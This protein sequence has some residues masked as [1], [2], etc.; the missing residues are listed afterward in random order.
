MK[1][2][3]FELTMDIPRAYKCLNHKVVRDMK[4]WRVIVAVTLLGLAANALAQNPI[5]SISGIVQEQMDNAG[6]QL[7]EQAAKH[8]EEGNLTQ[9][10]IAKDID[11][12]KKNLTMQA[13]SQLGKN[14][15]ATLDKLSEKAAE[16]LKSQMNEKVPVPQQPGFPVV[17]AVLGIL[18]TVCLIRK[19]V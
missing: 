17:L 5:E 2:K 7:R 13:K 16:D 18:G 15:S 8:I 11:A 1:R 12:T 9:E 6:Q 14:F 3:P 19:G 10:H 4:T